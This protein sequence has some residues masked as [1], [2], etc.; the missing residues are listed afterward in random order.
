MPRQKRFTIRYLIIA[1]CVAVIA[2]SGTL[3]TVASATSISA[4]PYTDFASPSGATPAIQCT[5]KPAERSG[6]WA[7][8]DTSSVATPSVSPDATPS[9][10]VFC[11]NHGCW[12]VFNDFFAEFNTTTI[13]YG[14]GA[15]VLGNEHILIEWHLTGAQTVA[16]PVQS[17]NSNYTVNTIFSGAL[18][19]GAVGK[20]NGGSLVHSCGP[21]TRPAAS[22]SYL[23]SYPGGC[24]LY[25]NHNYDHN[26]VIET[27]WKLSGYE[28]YW[29]AYQ[30]S[31]VMHAPD[32]A[33][34]RF[35]TASALPGSY[36]AAGYNG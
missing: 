35:S 12:T 6:A 22:A 7:C 1:V 33:I 4:V 5:K 17:R 28:G 14:I 27:S 2:I 23:V 9:R 26:M 10:S 15:K 8:I 13:T 18:Y 20:A 30:R 21:N 34:Y 19:N 32:K 16:S 36:A 25:D 31:P 29:W 24:N 3:T 11:D